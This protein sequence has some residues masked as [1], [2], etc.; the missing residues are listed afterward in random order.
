MSLPVTSDDIATAPPPPYDP[1][2][3]GTPDFRSTA[4]TEIDQLTQTIGAIENDFSLI[5]GFVV[6][7]D[8]S[9]VVKDHKFGEE[10]KRLHT[11]YSNLLQSSKATANDVKGHIAGLRADL[12]P[13]IQNEASDLTERK[14]ILRDYIKGLKSFET[15]AEATE[16]GL[17]HISNSVRA[18]QINLRSAVDGQH[19][20][21]ETAINELSTRISVFISIW[22]LLTVEFKQLDQLLAGASDQEL[23]KLSR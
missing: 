18:F 22:R 2:Y 23:K 11:E 12:L 14:L 17:E 5:E 7:L 21:N 19:T 20:Q 6:E 9:G 13:V 4:L 8:K 10:W 15:K 16:L 1:E 3:V